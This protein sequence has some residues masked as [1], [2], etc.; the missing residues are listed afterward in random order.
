MYMNF[1]NSQ[2][3]YKQ[4][5]DYF[6]KQLVRG[7]LH[8]GDRIPSQREYAERVRVNPNTVQRA[9][10]EM[11]IMQLVETIRGQGTFIS[12]REAMIQELRNEMVENIIGHFI[13]EMT[14]LGYQD[15]DLVGLLEKQLVK[16]R[17]GKK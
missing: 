10:R 15:R 16:E 7:E 5:I 2:P 4:I 1:N 13:L 9:Y 6:K 17:D 12:N 8:P 3:I 11:E 14:S